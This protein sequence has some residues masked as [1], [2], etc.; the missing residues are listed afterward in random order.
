MHGYRWTDADNA[1][2][3]PGS[4]LMMSQATVIPADTPPGHHELQW[5]YGTVDYRWTIEVVPR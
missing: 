4:D 5:C 2:V 3:A 1:V